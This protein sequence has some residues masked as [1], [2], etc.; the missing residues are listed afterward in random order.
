MSIDISYIDICSFLCMMQSTRWDMTERHMFLYRRTNGKLDKTRD[1]F[2]VVKKLGNGSLSQTTNVKYATYR[3]E[4]RRNCGSISTVSNFWQPL[5]HLR[6]HDDDLNIDQLSALFS[7][8]NDWIVEKVQTQKIMRLKRATIWR[9][10]THV[11]NHRPKCD[12]RLWT[13]GPVMPG[14][15]RT[16]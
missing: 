9:P 15:G 12:F 11:Y 3:S 13:V 7:M 4:W 16:T 1:C 2:P 14:M 10:M 6:L 5:K 8:R